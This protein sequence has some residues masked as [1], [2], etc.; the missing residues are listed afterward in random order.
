MSRVEKYIVRRARYTVYGLCFLGGFLCIAVSANA[1]LLPPK[2][3]KAFPRTEINP[4][5]IVSSHEPVLMAASAL[6]YDQENDVITAT[7][8]VEVTQGQTILLADNVSYDQAHN[9]VKARGHVSLLEPSGNVVFADELALKDDLKAGV[10]HQFKA[11]LSDNSLLV[12][13]T[14]RRINET[15]LELFKAAYTPCKCGPPD[16]PEVPQWQIKA[17]HILVDREENKVYYD[18]A[19]MAAF[20]VPVFYTPYLSHPTPDA[21]NESGLLTPEYRHSSN[22]GSILKV[23]VYLALSPDKDVTLTPMYT[24]DEGL[25]MIGEF[26]EKFDSGHMVWDGSITQPQRRDALGNLTSDTEIRGHIDGVGKFALADDYDWGFNIHRTTDDTYL[27]RYGFSNASML[28]SRIYT[29]G[30]NFIG[31]N[32]R[33]YGNIEGLSFQ[34]LAE[35]DEGKRTPVVVPRINFTAQSDPMIWNSRFTFD[36]NIQSLYR[37]VGADSQRI[38]TIAGW[39]L[40]YI[41]D[42]G[43]IIQLS[44]ELRSDLYEVNDVLLPNNQ[45]FDGT[46]GRL[47]PQASMLWRYPFIRQGEVTNLI[48]E[49]IV[50]FTLSPSG[51]NPDEIPNE[52][53]LVPEF[54]DGNLFST[55]RFA[56]LDRIETGPRVAYGLRGQ[57]QIFTDKYIDWLIGQN[58]RFNDDSRFPFSND[59]DSH[60]SDYVGKVGIAYQPFAL[61]YR[62][63]LDRDTFTARRNEIDSSINYYPIA[64][65]VSYVQLKNDPILANKQNIGA[66]LSINLSKDWTWNTYGSEDLELHQPTS[67]STGLTYKNECTEIITLLGRE[68]TR[69]RDLEPSTNFLFRISLKNLE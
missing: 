26:R 47:V 18:D 7:G 54:T 45:T 60:F 46:T 16:G 56:G 19:Y 11:R 62:F 2:T 67:T 6:D 21:G 10:I 9:T 44:T 59:L 53:S 65:A 36:G 63:R 40:P 13:A 4:E 34:G 69:D 64:L 8:K 31:D 29:E 68:Y 20:G 39:K 58:Y 50:E 12:A 49:P 5:P 33:T 66:N 43:Q 35:E 17:D 32:D 22:L 42:G 15:R 24:S 37:D 14:A 27:R 48:I 28:T 51:G 61:A 57:A 1:A 41:T 3:G 52:D 30:F 38:A 23:P 55:D 25:V